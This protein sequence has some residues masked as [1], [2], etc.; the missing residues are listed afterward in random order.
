MIAVSLFSCKRKG[1]ADVTVPVPRDTVPQEEV[2]LPDTLPRTS[3][4]F[5][6]G[7]DNS[8]FNQYYTLANYYY[9][10]N[11]QDKTEIV[12]DSMTS[13]LEVYNY[14][15]DNRPK[16]DRPYGLINL[17]SHGNQFVD[18]KA[19]VYPDGSRASTATLDKAIQDSLFLPLS[20]DIIDSLS[21]IYLHGCAI[22]NNKKLINKLGETF[23]REHNGVK[24]KASKYFEYYA[25]LAKNKNPSSIRH[26]FAKT[27][28]GFYNPDHK[29]DDQGFA[30]R[31]AAAYPDEDVNWMEG[32]QRCFQGNPSELYH[33]S[34]LVPLK[35]EEVFTDEAEVPLVNTKKRRSDWLENNREFSQLIAE[36]GVP[37]E[38]FQMRYYKPKY[39]RDGKDLYGLRVTARSGVLS[40]IQ[41]LLSDD[42][43]E[44]TR[45]VPYQPDEE[46]TVFFEFAE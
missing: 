13:M 34:F 28:Y 38:Y 17:V 40:L 8:D 16:N 24:V 7:K 25:Y 11:P 46:D 22:G 36:T 44:R 21:V 5:V 15:K 41:P 45:F 26:Y 43:E 3:I 14:L 1:G 37:L 33:F 12:I 27:W 6:L 39:K 32:V 30:D 42:E 23:G 9:R 4:T 20:T 18:L 29:P 35:W 19:R 2:F 31:L 10:L